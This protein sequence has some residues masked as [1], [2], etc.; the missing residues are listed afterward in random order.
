MTPFEK[1]IEELYK[2][3]LEPIIDSVHEDIMDDDDCQSEYLELELGEPDYI[4]PI[5]QAQKE[6]FLRDHADY[7]KEEQ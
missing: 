2:S 5:Y 4:D 7:F 3:E 1:E 6:S